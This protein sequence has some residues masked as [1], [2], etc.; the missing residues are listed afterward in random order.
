[1]EI[2]LFF[3]REKV[4]GK[5]LQV[6]HIPGCDQKVDILTKSL[7]STK[8]LELRDKLDVTALIPPVHPPLILWGCMTK[9]I[10]LLD[11]FLA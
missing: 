9:L 10:L 11:I 7:S 2:D 6:I 5:H 4:L 1:M 3:V 8:F